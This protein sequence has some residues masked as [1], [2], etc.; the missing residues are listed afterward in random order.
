MLTKSDYLRYLQ[1]QKYLW[2]HKN[3]KELAGE[4]TEAQQVMFDQGEEVE[5]YARQLFPAGKMVGRDVFAAEKETKDFIKDGAEVLYQATAVVDNLLAR[6]DIFQYDPAEKTW[7]IYE[8]KSPTHVESE[9]LSDICFQKVVFERAGY[10]IG[11]TFIIHINKEYVRQGDID[12]KALL[13][14]VDVTDKVE[15]L[16]NIV[17]SDIPKALAFTEAEKEP[18]VRI[19]K[20]CESPHPCPFMTHCWKDIP[21]YSVYDLNR[22]SEK[23][24]VQLLDDGVMEVANI[25]LDFPMTDTQLNQVTAAQTKEAIIDYPGIAASLSELQYPLYFLDYET[26][27]SAIPIFDGTKPYQQV[28]FQYSVHV[29]PEKGGKLE[30]YEFLARGRENPVPPLMTQL[31]KDIP[32]GHGTVLVWYK[33]FEMARNTE[34]GEMFPE[35]KDFFAGVNARV[36]DL[37]EVF[38]KQYYVHPK[39]KGSCSIKKVLPV[40]VPDLSYSDLEIQEGGMAMR[41]YHEM[42]FAAEMEEA[43][44]KIYQNLLKYCGQDTLAM[45]RI[46]EVL[47]ETLR[48][49]LS[50]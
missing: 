25:P 6:A 43:S 48:K 31:K 19:V 35:Y 20:Q 36:F 30:H 40:L 27:A 49:N 17:I 34:M 44:E 42:N 45:V 28:C 16:E 37:M 10:K 2:L 15:D 4:V 50:A 13:T 12:P 5:S 24:L 39:F 41:S 11:K 3:R 21:P 29:L 7:N 32:T 46:L 8:V 22:I 33:G 38:Q 47:E 26:F 9:H 1:C 18:N 23:K 14:V